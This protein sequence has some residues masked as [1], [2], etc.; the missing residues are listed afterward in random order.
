MVKVQWLA[1]KLKKYQ[2]FDELIRSFLN[3]IFVFNILLRD[4]EIKCSRMR[5]QVS[6]IKITL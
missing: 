4:A 1:S 2:V 6:I 3:K 5:M